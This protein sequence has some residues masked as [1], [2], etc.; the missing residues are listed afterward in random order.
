MSS[1]TSDFLKQAIEKVKSGT[2]PEKI[3]PKD[4]L[5]VTGE[6]V[7]DEKFVIAIEQIW[8]PIGDKA[9]IREGYYGAVADIEEYL[10]PKPPKKEIVDIDPYE[11]IF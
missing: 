11:F 1:L 8:L 6:K 3:F 7:F 4:F 10:R 9:F 2:P 5:E